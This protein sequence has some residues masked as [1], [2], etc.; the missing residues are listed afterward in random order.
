MRTFRFGAPLV[1]LALAMS[2]GCS[3]DLN[4]EQYVAKEEKSFAVSGK[5]E[6]EVKTFDGSVE[7]TSW[8]KPQVALTIERHAGSQAEA[9]TLKVNT[10]QTGNRIVVEAVKPE[11]NEV[12]VGWHQGRSVRFIV[13][14]PRQ[15]DLT[16]T[17]G[18]G[19]ISISGVTG[20]V[21]A[22]SGDGS[23]SVSDVSGDVIIH[24]GDGAVS[25]EQVS[26]RV[27]VST[28]DGSVTI[29]GAPHS[30][31]ARTG[32]GALDLDVAT[33]ASQADDW[34]LSTGDGGVSVVLPS[35]FNAQLDAH[36]GDGGI[37]ASDFGLRPSG[38][39]KND[40]QGTIGSGGRTLRI[41]TGDG[42]ITI[43]KK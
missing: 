3:I 41:R 6:L 32:D 30:L 16:A 13:R 18:D 5:A 37:D 15:T 24:T 39:E 12:H 33:S 34:D 29:K 19:A 2:V 31:K 10:T 38:E 4:A 25:A 27:D 42:G 36:T 17:S 23:I 8:D 28:G 35:G 22:R 21:S 7:V 43:R 20:A 26:G 40:L 11:R 1:V 9:D 14:V